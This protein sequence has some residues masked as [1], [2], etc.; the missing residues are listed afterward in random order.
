MQDK[1]RHDSILR[2]QWCVAA[3]P[4]FMLQF[5]HTEQTARRS[6][7]LEATTSIADA[8][9]FKLTSS[10]SNA[11]Q[12]FLGAA[13]GE[14]EIASSA[15]TVFQPAC[16]ICSTE[17]QAIA[18]IH[19]QSSSYRSEKQREA[20]Q[21]ILN[22][23]NCLVILPT[24]SGKS[25]TFLVSAVMFG[26]LHLIICPFLALIESHFEKITAIPG[27]RVEVITGTESVS[28]D[29]RILCG[30]D[31]CHIVLT[32]AETLLSWRSFR[33]KILHCE[34]LG[35][36]RCVVL[37]E[38][39]LCIDE[40]RAIYG[41]V[42]AMFRSATQIVGLTA[43]IAVNEQPKLLEALQRPYAAI[44]SETPLVRANVRLGVT[45]CK[46]Q[47]ECQS[48]IIDH[49]AQLYQCVK[50]MFVFCAAVKDVEHLAP[51]ISQ[52]LGVD[53]CIYHGQL[54]LEAK[55]QALHTINQHQGSHL[56]VIATSALGAG[57]DVPSINAVLHYNPP[58]SIND[59]V[60]QNGRCA[61]AV[62]SHG[63]SHMYWFTDYHVEDQAMKDYL[64]STDCR[65]LFL[66]RHFSGSSVVCSQPDICD[67]CDNDAMFDVAAEIQDAIEAFERDLSD[68]EEDILAQGDETLEH[69]VTEPIAPPV[70]QMTVQQSSIPRIIIS[71][72]QHARLNTFL[73][74]KCILCFKESECEVTHSHWIECP[75]LQHR[76]T[77]CGSLGHIK[78]NCPNYFRFNGTCIDC[79]LGKE[80]HKNQRRF[81]KDC[82]Y[83]NEQLRL[84]A[85]AGWHYFRDQL[86]AA[87]VLSDQVETVYQY[88]K[89]V[90][91]NENVLHVLRCIT[92]D[93][94]D[95]W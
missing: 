1:L 55:Q 23:D 75:L 94:P 90:S 58:F 33:R 39:H 63:T 8:H 40:F 17:Q 34:A 87:Q 41:R 73:Q 38:A 89:W 19:G 79:F 91:A 9:D 48:M 92:I 24:G 85:I 6:Y 44:I 15:T 82:M 46:S 13:D 61:R 95:L 2:L 20:C 71:D 47:L 36:L 11:W 22:G 80:R 18:L 32:T 25:T 49:A 28:R 31:R 70:V 67:V 16:Q 26:G 51:Q 35:I 93:V 76:C 64:Y 60:Q 74:R 78:E 81:T 88:M 66:E 69:G 65:L 50:Y 68:R 77:F 57:V 4:T 53:V 12:I 3:D 54:T 29:E 72:P 56:V 5:G 30:L 59:Y 52:R 37:D 27:L 84:V 43:T 45:R 10:A 14:E 86:I 83:Q 7:G 62:G 42:A 21:R